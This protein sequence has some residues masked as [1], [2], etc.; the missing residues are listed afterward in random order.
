MGMFS[1]KNVTPIRMQELCEIDLEIKRDMNEMEKRLVFDRRARVGPIVGNFIQMA[2]LFDKRSQNLLDQSMCTEVCPCL[3]D[4]NA[5]LKYSKIREEFLYTHQ[6]QFANSSSGQNKFKPFFWTKDPV[7]GI[8]T[9]RDCMEYY[10]N[11]K[12]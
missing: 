10:Q 1:L 6:R 9:F 2:Q 8:K 4:G 5:K 3:D 11:M 12:Q 7:R